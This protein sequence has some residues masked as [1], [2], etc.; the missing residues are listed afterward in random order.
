MNDLYKSGTSMLMDDLCVDNNLLNEEIE[1]LKHVNDMLSKNN[2]DVRKQF[3]NENFQ[4][5]QSLDWCQ[6]QSIEMELQLQSHNI[7]NSC[8]LCKNLESFKSL[9]LKYEKEIAD[10]EIENVE[11]QQNR[12]HIHYCNGL[13]E[14][15]IQDKNHIII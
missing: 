14:S 9:C 15:D 10:L 11:W 12:D 8:Q 13:L 3:S 5:K 2:D 6:A 4:L 1:K 7:S